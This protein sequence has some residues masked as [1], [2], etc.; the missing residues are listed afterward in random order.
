M[1]HYSLFFSIIMI[2]VAV[3]K[4]HE[5]TKKRRS[6]HSLL[7]N[8]NFNVI[9]QV[10]INPNAI[11]ARHPGKLSKVVLPGVPLTGGGLASR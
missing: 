6:N 7:E 3:H 9:L 1:I 4:A 11:M 8:P 10:F 5:N 2:T